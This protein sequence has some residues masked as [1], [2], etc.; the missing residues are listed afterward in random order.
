MKYPHPFKI[1]IFDLH[2]E[3]FGCTGADISIVII[4]KC[5]FRSLCHIG[6]VIT[7]GECE[8]EIHYPFLTPSTINQHKWR[9]INTRYTFLHLKNNSQ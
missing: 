6:N 2:N 1:A 4:L 9:N 8:E 3:N 7:D 5:L